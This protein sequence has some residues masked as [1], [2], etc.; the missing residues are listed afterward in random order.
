MHW[1]EQIHF[2]NNTRDDLDITKWSITK[3]DWLHSLQQKMDK[4]HTDSKNKTR[5]WLWFR[6]SLIAKFRFKLKKVGKTT[7]PFRYDLNQIPHDYT[8][9]VMNRFKAIRSSRQSTWKLWTEVHNIVQEA[10][11]KPSQRKEMQECKVVVW[12][13]LTNSWGKKRSKK[14]GRKGKVYPTKCRVPKNSK[15]RQEGLLQWTMQRN[16]GKQWKRND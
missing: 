10:V 12:G 1:S 11:T 8:W 16:K 2:S 7:R 13:G 5:S 9:E 14:Q 15:E 6:S 4:Y 3:S